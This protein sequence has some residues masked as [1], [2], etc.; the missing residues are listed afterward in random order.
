MLCSHP[1][2]ASCCSTNK[3][4][5]ATY[6]WLYPTYLYNLPSALPSLPRSYHKGTS[7]EAHY[8]A[9]PSQ[10]ALL[11]ETPKNK[12]TLYRE[13]SKERVLGRDQRPWRL[14]RTSK[15]SFQ[16]LHNRENEQKR[17]LK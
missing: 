17:L 12:N 1:R 14:K 15:R 4:P 5:S 10:P 2:I 9:V 7:Y 11:K 13:R 6:L 8:A 3:L 16:R